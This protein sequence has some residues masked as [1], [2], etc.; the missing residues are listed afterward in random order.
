MTSSPDVVTSE[1]PDVSVSSSSSDDAATAQMITG[2]LASPVLPIILRVAILLALDVFIL[3]GNGFTLLTIRLT[4]RLWTKTNFILAS[5]LASDLWNGVNMLWYAPYLLVAY[6]FSDD[7]CRYNVINTAVAP[8]LLSPGYVSIYHLILISVERYIAIV[9]PLHY[10]TMF[11]DRTLKWAIVAVWAAGIFISS[12]YTLWLI[13]ADLNRCDLV[14]PKFY[15]VEILLGY[16]PVCVSLF[17]CYGK[18]LAVWWRQRRRTGPQPVNVDPAHG[19]SLQT[20]TGLTVQ[21]PTQ[22]SAAGHTEDSKDH[23]L[24]LTLTPVGT[25]PPSEPG[26]TSGSSASEELTQEQQR[27]KI[28]TRC[29]EYKAVYLTATIVGTFVV[30]WYV[31]RRPHGC[32]S[33]SWMFVVLW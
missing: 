20:A 29:R 31:V 32:S 25:G 28:K 17:A 18:I 9:H 2:R 10:E 3:C 16:V 15:L 27:Q 14:R 1:S 8:L 30:L 23:P 11:T 22:T 7:P 26:V 12:T 24:T 5:L 21:R 6:V 19:P 33:S 13:N 4:R